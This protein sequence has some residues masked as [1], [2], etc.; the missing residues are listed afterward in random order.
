MPRVFGQPRK[1]ERDS[2]AAVVVGPRQIVPGRRGSS[3]CRRVA[4]VTPGY[5]LG[6]V[7]TVN[8]ALADGLP[9]VLTWQTGFSLALLRLFA[10]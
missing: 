8:C 3:A 7:E 6:G 5:Y 10:H 9:R 4:F 2:G 1:A